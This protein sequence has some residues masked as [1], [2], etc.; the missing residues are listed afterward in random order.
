[1]CGLYLVDS[2]KGT[3]VYHVQIKGHRGCNIK[4]ALT[5]NWL[6]YHYFEGEV[7]D[8]SVGGTKGYRMVTV[9]LYEG[10][11]VDEK[12][13]RCGQRFLHLYSIC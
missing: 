8:G 13:S 3:V 5:E 12:T 2:T 6:V 4:M 7:A 11:V 10:E 1:M 9:E